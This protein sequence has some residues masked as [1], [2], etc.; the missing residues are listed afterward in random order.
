MERE[1]ISRYLVP[2]DWIR[3]DVAAVAG[4][5]IA[6]K[7]ESGVLGRLP[8]LSQ[9]IER[10]HEEQ[11]RLEAVATTQIE[12]AVF[13][14]RERDAIFKSEANDAY[15]LSRSQRQLRAAANTYQWIRGLDSARPV[16]A[17]LIRRIHERIV[18][19]CDDDRC[20]PGELRSLGVEANF[21]IPR[22]RGAEEGSELETAFQGLATAI[23]SEFKRHDRIVQALA[24]HYH[25]GAMHPFGDGNG[26]TARA[27]EAFM[28]RTAGVNEMVMVS[29]SSYYHAH[30]DEYLSVLYQ[31]R[32]RDH[33]LTTFLEFGLRAIASRCSTLAGEI[34]VHSKRILYREFARSLSRRKRSERRRVI[35]ERQLHIIEALLNSDSVEARSLAN[36]IRPHYNH[37]KHVPRAMRRD[38]AGLLRISAITFDGHELAANLDW[39]QTFSESDLL[40]I[41]ESMPTA[42]MS[43]FPIATELSRLL[44]RDR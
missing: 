39:P 1:P 5:L 32:E 13:S 6:A 2:R 29:L 7:T 8:R 14:D 31:S 30:Q 33:D 43:G 9:W 22:C 4:A 12:G 18:H 40:R 37:L 38:L 16:G 19:E 24:A 25:V 17:D 10:A 36:Q 34:S 11:L 3:Y 28:L 21:G 15:G 41:F 20:Q 35:T 26:R 23:G 42:A 27:L 44:G